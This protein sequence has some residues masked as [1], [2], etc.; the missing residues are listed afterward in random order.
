MPNSLS[1]KEIK[2]IIQ[3]DVKNWKNALSFWEAHFSIKPGMRVLALGERQGGLSLYFAKMGCEVVCTEYKEPLDEAREMHKK[4][5]V[6]ERITYQQ[7]D[8]R[9]IDFADQSFDIVVFKSVIGAL[10]SVN[11]QSQAI[12]E[13]RRVLKKDGAFLFAENAV[14][15]RLH[16]Y[17]RKKFVNWKDAWRYVSDEEFESWK[18]LF[19]KTYSKKTGLVALF[20]RS[21]KQRSFLGAVDSLF[22]PISPKAWRYIYLGVFIR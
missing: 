10:S 7:M 4:Y 22:S 18:K 3:W 14:A 16:R 19:S 11:D 21:E 5:G 20:G 17:M 1:K 13:I 9:K 8:M 15:S 6:S 12:S 2:D